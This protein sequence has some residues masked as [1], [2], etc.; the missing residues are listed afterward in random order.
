[1]KYKI[2]IVTFLF[3]IINV[4]KNYGNIIES[5]PHTS[6]VENIYVHI[7]SSL[8]FTGEYLYFKIYSLN[9]NS[10]FSKISK[11]VHFDIISENGEKIISKNIDLR[12]GEGNGDVFLPVTIDS[13]NYKILAYTNWMLINKPSRFF[14][15]D[16]FI[17]NPYTNNQKNIKND[18]TVLSLKPPKESISKFDLLDK[19]VY[20][21]RSEVKLNLQRLPKGSYS[22]SVHLFEDL[23]HPKLKSFDSFN[24]NEKIA[25]DSK[26]TDK[27]IPEIYGQLVTGVVKSNSGDLLQNKI[28]SISMGQ[29]NRFIKLVKIKEDGK[30][31]AN[32]DQAFEN[33]QAIFQLLSENEID[34]YEIQLDTTS[35]G[36]II[37]SKELNF[38]HT[39]ISPSSEEMI[40]KRSVYNQIENSY[41]S[42]KPDTIVEQEKSSL[43]ENFS[44]VE[45]NLN[46][47]TRFKTLEE[48]FIEIIPYAKV[49]NRKNE[50]ELAVL[51]YLPKQNF[52]GS[53]LVLVDGIPL[54]NV[55]MFVQNYSASKIEKI[56]IIR[57]KCFISGK[58]YKGVIML[59]TIKNDFENSS[60][61]DAKYFTLNTGF[62]DKRYFKQV[63]KKGNEYDHMPDFRIQL[64]WDPDLNVDDA[65][66]SFYTSDV[67][68]KFE[69]KVEGLT[70]KGKP[71]S[72][73]KF[74]EVRDK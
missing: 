67:T 56:K 54:Q 5:K 46:D 14:S 61:L 66:S 7:N 11:I 16:I 62:P 55:D 3:F 68:G 28:L 1:M 73:Q 27:M 24:E 8:L 6:P 19:K 72:I 17:L 48:T 21:K 69:V 53:P 52:D 23:S 20:S 34:D 12:E 35:L 13:G 37:N 22:I 9:E 26:Y 2:I 40:R 33:T 59:E 32:I 49:F 51:G 70:D 43:F 63:Y 64:L 18:S 25:I 65:N 47:Y 57:D 44:L 38:S 15:Q 45:Y 10:E 41:Y 42:Q 30:F 36:D 60:Y 4:N 39:F 31:Y 50:Y 58:I 74:F 29:K 71:I